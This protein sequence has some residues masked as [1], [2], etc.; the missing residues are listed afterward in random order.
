MIQGDETLTIK[1]GSTNRGFSFVSWTDLYNRECSLQKS[2]I[3]TADCY[4]LGVDNSPVS[5]N[6]PEGPRKSVDDGRMHLN[7]AQMKQLI[8]LLRAALKEWS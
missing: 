4:W 5:L 6:E 8:K 7:R 1:E 2:S 3:A